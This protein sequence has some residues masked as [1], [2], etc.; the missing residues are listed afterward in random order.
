MQ[1]TSDQTRRFRGVPAVLRPHKGA[2]GER[3]ERWAVAD[4]GPRDL[5]ARP[6]DFRNPFP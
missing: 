6:F 4:K 3:A 5:A 1:H 2:A